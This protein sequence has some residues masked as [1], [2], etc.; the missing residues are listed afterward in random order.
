MADDRWKALGSYSELLN[1]ED[2]EYRDYQYNI[3]T[4]VLSRGNSLVVLPTGL[5]KTLIGAAVMAHAL[6]RGERRRSSSPLRNL[7]LSSITRRC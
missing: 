4:S 1:L 2:A 6:D 5:G 7:S 3:I